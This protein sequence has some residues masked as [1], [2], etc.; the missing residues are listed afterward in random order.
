[1]PIDYILNNSYSLFQYCHMD[2]R[3]RFTQ[4]EYDALESTHRASHL[5]CY[6]HW[7]EASAQRS[8]KYDAFSLQRVN[9][10][11]ISLPLPSR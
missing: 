2:Y 1:L 8:I 11:S 3:A 7:D 9:T 5:I 4:R 10:T 6:S